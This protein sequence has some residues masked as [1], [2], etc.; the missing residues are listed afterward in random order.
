MRRLKELDPKLGCHFSRAAKVCVITYARA[1][2]PPAVIMRVENDD[3]EFRIPDQ[4]DINK[5]HESDNTRYGMTER[6]EKVAKYM[7]DYREDRKREVHAEIKER[8]ADDKYQLA[9]AFAQ[10]HCG[11][12]GKVGR[13]VRRMADKPRGKVF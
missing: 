6:H 4:R 2:G 8:T 12:S 9:R 3:D 10:S 5:L 7:E 1:T 13:H 11:A